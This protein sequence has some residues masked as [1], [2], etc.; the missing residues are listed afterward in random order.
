MK[1][2]VRKTDALK[3]WHRNGCHY[4]QHSA[5][6]KLAGNNK[7]KMQDNQIPRSPVL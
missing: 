3:N 2:K 5:K 6:P 4:G 7:S 1:P